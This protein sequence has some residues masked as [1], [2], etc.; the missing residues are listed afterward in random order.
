MMKHF[1][2]DVSG[3]F[4]DDNVPILRAQGFTEW[5]NEDDVNH[6]PLQSP[7]F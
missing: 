3:L 1:Y 4:Q 6:M 2:P 5:F 7:D